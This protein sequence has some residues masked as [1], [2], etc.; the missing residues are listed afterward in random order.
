MTVTALLRATAIAARNVVLGANVLSL[1]LLTRPQLLAIYATEA[2]ALLSRITET[3]GLQQRNVFDVLSPGPTS[4]IV[5]GA[6]DQASVPWFRALSHQTVDIVSLCLLCQI[7]APKAVFEIGTLNGYSALHFALNSPADAKIYTLDLPREHVG[8]L[9]LA[10]TV[11]DDG[12]VERGVAVKEYCFDRSPVA[13]KIECLFG[14][15]ATFAFAPFVNS[16]DLFFID[17]AH[18]YEYVRSDTMRALECCRPGSVIAWHDFG[19]MGINGVS[20]W[21]REFA[22]TRPVYSVPGGSLA[23]HVVGGAADDR[24]EPAVPCSA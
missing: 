2:I 4:S 13:Y 8:P 12:I 18:S 16:V 23:F 15:S 7:L 1:R 20:K 14:D 9:R 19:R 24:S 5:L 10:T 3:R 21:L 17:G 11:F 22:S 6:L